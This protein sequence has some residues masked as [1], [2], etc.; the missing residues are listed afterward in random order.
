[1]TFAEFAGLYGLM[2]PDLYPSER[3][4]LCPIEHHPRAKDGAY[5]GDGGRG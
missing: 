4:G 3:V 5:F 2:L 1:M